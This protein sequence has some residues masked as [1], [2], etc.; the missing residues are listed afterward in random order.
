MRQDVE[1]GK[2]TINWVESRPVRFEIHVHHGDHFVEV[3]YPDSPSSLE[4]ADY[5]VRMKRVMDEIEGEWRC[6]VD[7]RRMRSMSPALLDMVV[8]LTRR[9]VERGLV[10]VARLIEGELAEARAQARRIGAEA[11]AEVRTFTSRDSAVAWL[12]GRSIEPCETGESTTG[13]SGDA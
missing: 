12:Q 11:Q 10:R 1:A 2:V 7:Q 5:M 4:T 3:V 8:G 13:A 9:A 6:L